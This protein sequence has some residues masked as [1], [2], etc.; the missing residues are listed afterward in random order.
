MSKGTQ[1]QA[2][3]LH[4]HGAVTPGANPGEVNL[5]VQG[6]NWAFVKNELGFEVQ[7][8]GGAAEFTIFIEREATR[9]YRVSDVGIRDAAQRLWTF[10]SIH[11]FSDVI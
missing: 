6:T 11:S 3:Q 7:D 4:V 2:A 1:G 10:V 9:M 5:P 8:S